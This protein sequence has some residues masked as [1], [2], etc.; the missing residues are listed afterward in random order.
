MSVL[1]GQKVSP[2][3]PNRRLRAQTRDASSRI[4]RVD[5]ARGEP[6]RRA[7][8]PDDEPAP[9]LRAAPDPVASPPRIEEAEPAAEV[10][11]RR[12][13][14]V[15]A[16]IRGAA[17]RRAVPAIDGAGSEPEVRARPLRAATTR[18]EGPA[19]PAP[20]GRA[21]P[22]AASSQR[23]VEI[24]IAPRSPGSPGVRGAGAAP[25]GSGRT[26][27]L[28]AATLGGSL[29]AARVG[30]GWATRLPL[31]LAQTVATAALAAGVFL[32]ASLGGMIVVGR[33]A[34]EGIGL[35]GR[36]LAFVPILVTQGWGA[37][38]R[39]LRPVAV[40]V[41]ALSRG[42]VLGELDEIRDGT[43]DLT[44]VGQDVAR[45]AGILRDFAVARRPNLPRIQVPP[46]RRAALAAVA[47]LG[48][49]GVLW[50]AALGV[51]AL[52][53]ELHRAS[54]LQVHTVTVE[55]VSRLSREEVLAAAGIRPRVNVLEVDL[56]A[57]LERM[58]SM[59]WVRTAVVKRRFPDRI[60]IR[61]EERE[62]T[63]L[64][65]AGG[66]WLVDAGGEVF[67]PVEPGESYDL[68]VVTGVAPPGSGEA[69]EATASLRAALRVVEAFQG[70]RRLTPGDIGEIRVEADGRLRVFTAR[71][72]V[73][74]KLGRE[75][76]DQRVGRL[77]ALLD[78]DLMTLSAVESV[79]LDLADEAVVRPRTKRRDG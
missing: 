24:P 67:K 55:G 4:S 69:G 33:R 9:R 8:P 29:A 7:T 1:D 20:R 34:G 41:E 35:A 63:A 43:P 27:A 50:G 62:P 45:A 59:P 68:P 78:Q 25:E 36:L 23:S 44:Q 12:F 47:G 38:V 73:E 51:W 71:E 46:P 17:S 2:R 3:Q 52:N 75:S 57:A 65:A 74:L 13:P 42:V 19:G 64:L 54:W 5:A 60:S 40:R 39:G 30:A 76:W 61:V 10:R 31:A 28:A 66:L 26:A 53:R 22:I 48:I 32:A 77:D 16:D 79:D 15:V 21:A 72:G 70:R 56:E 14:A 6:S 49:G 18:D 11:P 37:A 58:R